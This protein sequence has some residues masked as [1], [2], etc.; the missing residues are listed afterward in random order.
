MLSLRPDTGSDRWVR[1]ACRS[2]TV[3]RPNGLPAPET[4]VYVDANHFALPLMDAIHQTA[5]QAATLDQAIAKITDP[6]IKA[7]LQAMFERA[8]GKTDA[9]RDELV[10]WFDSAMRRV[11]GVYKRWTK[12]ISVVLA[13]LVAGLFNADPIHL[14]D[15]LWDRPA[16]AAQLAKLE[17]PKTA[18]QAQAPELL[19]QIEAMG[20]LLGWGNFS[21]DKRN[22]GAGLA[23]ML[24]GWLIA[25][26]AALF[27]APFWFDVLQRF[28]QLRGTGS[29]P[30]S[31]TP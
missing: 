7:T 3:A 5:D 25:A 6:Q 12:L 18:D 1:S 30:P 31:P 24:L 14:A 10:K 28:V 4:R 22:Q 17:P 19:R 20:P 29:P 13:L 16:V 11:S 9:F 23:L 21:N 2:V 27:G 8:S 26:G 15:T